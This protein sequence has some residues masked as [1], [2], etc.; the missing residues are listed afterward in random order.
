VSNIQIPNL[1]VAIAL[2]GTEALEAVQSG[3]SVQ[4]TV[5]GIAQYSYAY[6]PGFYISQLPAASSANST[7]I[8]PVVQGSTGPN[9]GT[10]GKMTLAAAAL[11]VGVGANVR[12][13]GATG[14]GVTDDTAAFVAAA[15]SLTNGGVLLVPAGTYMVSYGTGLFSGTQVR[16]AGRQATRIKAIAGFPGSGM[17]EAYSFFYNVNWNAASLAAGDNDISVSGIT[18]DYSWNTA[19]N[20]MHPLNFRY[21]TRLLIEDNYFFYGGNSIA[22]RGCE[23]TWVVGNSGYEFR[24]CAWDFW[25]GP[26]TTYVV[27]NYAETSQTAQMMNFNPEVSPVASSPLYVIGKRLVVQGNVFRCT[28]AASEPCQIEPLSNRDNGITDVVISGNQFHR[29]YLVHRGYVDRL[30][31]ANN[32]FNDYPDPN[33]SVIIVSPA[34]SYTPKAV[35]IIGNVITDPGTNSANFGVIRCEVNS[36]TVTGNVIT[37]TTYTGAPFYQGTALPNQYGNWFEKLGITGRM[38]QGFVITN[39]NGTNNEQSCI[40]WEDTSGNPLRMFMSSNFHQFWSTD[41][42]GAARQIWSMQA[43]SDTSQ[44]NVIVGM[45]VSGFFRTGVSVGLT[46]TGTTQPGA[47]GLVQNFNEVTTVAA[48]SGVRLPAGTTQ[49]VTGLE[50]TVWNVGANTLNVYPPTAAQINALGLNLPDTIAAGACKTYVGLSSALY[51]IKT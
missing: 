41:G 9:T 48:G 32:T 13:F 44:F 30:I 43:L 2:N 47:L 28:G 49:S 16:G 3:A 24:N 29:S 46:A 33:T 51:R 19:S 1:P 45:L 22:C 5:A 37:G 25:E 10:T 38:R 34:N 42:S 21:V 4:T 26:G 14:D 20:A 40:A 7:D 11:G 23:E 6:Y 36:A 35:S 39:P 17:S 15:A 18:F 12:A 27:N 8:F 50:V 31:I